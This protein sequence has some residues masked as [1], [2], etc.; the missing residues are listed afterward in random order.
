MKHLRSLEFLSSSLND[1]VIFS[2]KPDKIG[3]YSVFAYEMSLDFLRKLFSLIEIRKVGKLYLKHYIHLDFSC[4]VYFSSVV[5][6]DFVPIVKYFQDEN[7]NNLLIFYSMI[8]VQ[9]H[10]R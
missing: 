10:L 8:N 2:K 1:K 3:F 5:Q 4:S 9:K 6:V 7:G